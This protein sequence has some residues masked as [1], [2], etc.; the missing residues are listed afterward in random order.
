[1]DLS[2]VTLIIPTRNE[3]KNII[4]FLDN[5]PAH[6][7]LVII[8]SSNDRTRELINIRRPHNTEVIF[9]KCNIPKARQMGADIATTD[10]LIFSDADVIFDKNYFS[11]LEKINPAARIAAIMGAK[12]SLDKYKWYY[13]LYSRS[14]MFF[15]WF[16]IPIGTGSNMII[17]KNVLTAVGGF[18]VHLSVSED[19][20]IL[21]RIKKAGKKVIYKHSLKVFEFDHR[22]LQK[23]VLH[24]YLQSTLRI[25][26][27]IFGIRKNLQQS[28]WGYWKDNEQ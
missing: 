3:E 11:N 10:W 23:G 13:I 28:D 18:D 9:E 21:W 12:L 2:H 24:K 19:S 14:M 7:K 22:R 8:D 15:S 1:M 25:L 6:L 5:I 16:N 26:F 17:N 20:D 27:L 4:T